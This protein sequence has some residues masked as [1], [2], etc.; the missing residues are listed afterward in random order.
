M[1]EKVVAD[2]AE[3]TWTP[4]DSAA[5]YGL[6]D[7]GD[8]Y[9]NVLPNGHLQVR[10]RGP[11]GPGIDL[12]DVV[13]G[14]A[15]RGFSSPVLLRFSDLLEHR[16]GAIRGA[17]DRAIE[18]YEYRG[19]YRCLY[20][21]KV[22]QQ[23]H[24]C[25]EVRDLATRFDFGL[26]AGSKPELFGVLGLT[27]D[28]PEI[29]IVCNGFKDE[30]FIETVIL[31][32]KLGRDITPIVEKFSEL[33][34]II[35]QAKRHG[36]SPTIGIRVKLS[37]AGS[38][39]W[40]KSGGSRSKFGLFISE[41]MRAV[42]LLREHD[43]LQ[44]LTLVHSHIG[45]Q[46][47]DVR[48]L[49][50]VVNELAR[51]YAELY[52]LGTGVQAIDIG[53]GLGVDYDGSQTATASSINYTLDSYAVE[54]I[55]RIAA[56]CDEVGVP[57]PDVYSESGRAMVA[58]S[59]VLVCNVLGSARYDGD[60]DVVRGEDSLPTPLQELWDVH[61]EL[62]TADPL[63]NYHWACRAYD[64]TKTLFALGHMSLT[65]RA[66]AESLFWH[67]LHRLVETASRDEDGLPDE[68]AEVAD[69][70]TDIYFCNFSLFQSL[71]DS[72]A[73]DQIFPICPI[74][75]LDRE[76]RRRGILADITCD[77]D[78]QIDCF[79]DRREDKRILEL[80]ELDDLE[81]EPYYIGFFLVGAYQEILGDLHNLLGDTHAVHI[82][83][84]DE[85]GRS[86]TSSKATPSTRCSATCSGTPRSCA[87]TS[88]ARSRRRCAAAA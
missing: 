26:E 22:N 13:E 14:L 84:D 35:E 88:V 12:H 15:E 56:V 19:R 66:T 81:R 5:L 72:W 23:R 9:F 83:V 11:E 50:E 86:R 20:P 52:Q 74:H 79:A 47:N 28:Q 82:R 54:V 3:T 6:E 46:I 25:E 41:L 49:Q 1:S 70:L 51:I 36:V 77:S 62:A 71:P 42:E 64:Q 40:E 29:P 30:E 21:I 73:V 78:G 48:S 53:G 65:H 76:P 37:S 32:K 38:G 80:H 60:L 58:Y 44:C 16:L 45:S 59:S 63:E 17:F 69:K 18:S 67:I 34:M 8:G 2:S 57:H 75:R 7:W 24:V 10:P 39:R 43:M 61:A 68:L 31:A 4:E 87:T 55:H 27:A 85:T 33:E